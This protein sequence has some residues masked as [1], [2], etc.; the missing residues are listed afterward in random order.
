MLAVY[1]YILHVR[2][3]FS[4]VNGLTSVYIQSKPESLQSRERSNSDSS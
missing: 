1:L 3:S 2:H 4:V